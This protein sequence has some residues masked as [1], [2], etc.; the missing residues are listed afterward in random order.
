MPELTGRRNRPL[1]WWRGKT[2]NEEFMAT[3]E[4][5]KREEVV[6]STARGSH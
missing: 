4:G 2:R 1:P 5:E 6:E 3:V